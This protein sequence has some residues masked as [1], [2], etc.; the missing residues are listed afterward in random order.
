MEFLASPDSP[1]E[2]AAFRVHMISTDPFRNRPFRCGWVVLSFLFGI[3]LREVS[4]DTL[5]SPDGRIELEVSW[6]TVGSGSRPRWSARFQ[7]RT[8]ITEAEL[9]LLLK[10]QGDV[11]AGNRPVS[12]VRRTYRE[13]VG[14]PFGKASHA[15]D[16]FNEWTVTLKPVSGVSAEVVFRCYQDAVAF[17]YRLKRLIPDKAPLVVSDEV[18]TFAPPPGLNARIQVLENH[19]TSHEHRVQSLSS[20]EIPVG[21]LLDLPLSFFAADGLSMA[22]TEAALS[23]YPGM[24]LERLSGEHPEPRL[25]ARLTP[26][27]DGS[28]VVRL[29]E[30]SSPWRVL[31]VGARP[32][33]LLESTTVFCLNEPSRIPD[34]T[35]IQPGKVTFSWWNGDVYDGKRGLP[36]LSFEM[37]KKYVDFCADQGIPTHSLTSTEDTVTPWYQQTRPGVEPGPDTDVTRP[38]PGF[39]LEKIHRYARSKGVRLWTWVHNRALKGR[40]EEAFAAFER[41]G[42]S[43]MMVDF[44]DHDDQ[45]T[46]EFAEDI[47]QSAARHHILIHLHGIWKPTGLERTY[48][49][50]M[51]HEGALNLEHLKWG[52]VC[53]PSHDVDMAFTRLIAGPMDYHLGGFRSLPTSRFRARMIA[54]FVLGTRCHMLSMYVCF[55][56][57]NPMVADYPEA[58]R[59]QPGFDFLRSVPTWWDET[60]V[61][62]A[63]VG[64]HLATARR[65]GKTWYVG[66]LSSG[67]SHSITLPLGTLSPDSR[68][69]RAWQDALGTDGDPNRLVQKTWVLESGGNLT[70]PL[71]DDGGWVGVMDASR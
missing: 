35:W 15:Q 34:R 5:S 38:R 47:L 13:Q 44:F 3:G 48:P 39:E 69:V 54:P 71:G 12:E 68:T 26:H 33:A 42:W 70:V 4:A 23:R 16:H 49:N 20:G 19:R 61:L 43:G 58:Y 62:D 9:G 2:L 22:I 6:P 25:I 60:R 24:A 28:K 27:A 30:I 36:I 8:L 37:A 1:A 56:N 57:P 66:V 63:R 55:D 17:R 52:D 45:E 53:T 29:D 7:G 10:E 18:T 21:K 51:N 14:M 46:V 64:V 40:V 59:D 50:L 32:G 31:L 67:K 11:L 65:K 41:M